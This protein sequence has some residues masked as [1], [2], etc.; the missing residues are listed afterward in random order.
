[1]RRRE[2]FR[3]CGYKGDFN[4]PNRLHHRWRSS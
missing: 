1:V 2:R 4:H 3:C